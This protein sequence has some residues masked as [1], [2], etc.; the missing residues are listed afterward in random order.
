MASK[1]GS[2]GS[3]QDFIA[4]Q[5][6]LY[7]IKTGNPLLGDI[8]LTYVLRSTFQC[9]TDEASLVQMSPADCA[10]NIAATL[11][12]LQEFG[13]A[14]VWIRMWCCGAIYSQY[15][16][17]RTTCS[18][19]YLRLVGVPNPPRGSAWSCHQTFVA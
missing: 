15:N 11:K 8:F 4:F 2:L 16:T 17:F 10:A 3:R 7:N 13:I 5:Q 14:N 12:S 6:D 19:C 18:Q 1:K 9:N